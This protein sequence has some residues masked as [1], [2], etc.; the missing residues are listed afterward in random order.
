MFDFKRYLYIQRSIAIYI[1]YIDEYAQNEI[2][3]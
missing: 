3:R 1:V 2:D